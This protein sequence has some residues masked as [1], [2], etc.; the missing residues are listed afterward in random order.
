MVVAFF[1]EICPPNKQLCSS[2]RAKEIFTGN[3]TQDR[4][5][6]V[7][8]FVTVIFPVKQKRFVMALFFHHA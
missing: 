1:P 5:F 8:V 2:L 4:L 6:C 3:Q 7:V